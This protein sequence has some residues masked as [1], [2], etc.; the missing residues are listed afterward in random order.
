MKKVD[1]KKYTDFCKAACM[2]YGFP[3]DISEQTARLLV[4]TDKLGIFT[5]GTFGLKLYLQKVT[6]G[7][8]ASDVR[9]EVVSEGPSWAVVDGKNGMPVYNLYYG[10]EKAMEKAAETGVSYVGVKGSGHCGA[11]GVY[12]I[13]AAERGYIALVMSVSSNCMHVPGGRGRAI[14]N[15]PLSY[16]FP[17]GKHRPV[18]MD[19]AMSL[20]AGTKIT[21]ARLAG[22]PI[23]EGWIY[24]YDGKPTTDYNKPYA[25]AP[26]AGH[27]GYCLAFMV[28]VLCAVLT[29]GGILSEQKLWS[30]LSVV[31]DF[32]HCC[33]V[34]DTRQIMD[35]ETFEAR[36]AQAIN[37][38]AT[39]PR[40]EGC[41]RIWLPG[42]KE[43]EHF[44][45]AEKEG[46]YLPD[47]IVKRMTELSQ[48][49]G[50]PIEDCF[51]GD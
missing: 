4:K 8:M 46:L 16:A 30:N 31:P 13:E 26:M 42:E 35:M 21:R 29:G 18:F 14:G 3:E 49:T 51:V 24:D 22:E 6:E 36:M 9:P 1:I 37:E 2:Y 28:E 34:I 19:I 38:L 5:H 50:I 11:C 20:V 27:K 47:D 40:A 10:V 15:S 39:F 33:I 41:D 32:S 48:I 45:K 44:E 7:G 12:S 23:P 43:W 17:A 25:F